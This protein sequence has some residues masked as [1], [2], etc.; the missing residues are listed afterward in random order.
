MSNDRR[1]F[2]K[3]LGVTAAAV[4]GTGCGVAAAENGATG[5]DAVA[6]GGA[7]ATVATEESAIGLA[8]RS[9]AKFG[10]ELDGSFAG[11]L[12]STEGGNAT[13]DVVTEKLGPDGIAKKHLAGVKY[14]D[15]T[16]NCGAG[17][18]KAFFQ[19]I[20]DTLGLKFTRKDGAVIESDQRGREIRRLDFK[21]ALISELDLPALDAASR[22]AAK[23]TL[24][25]SPEFTRLNQGSGAAIKFDT[26]VTL[27]WRTSDFKLKIDGL[28]EATSHA[29][30]IEAITIKQKIVEN[31]I[32]EQRDFEKVPAGL[33]FGDVHVTVPDSRAQSFYD[34][35]QDFIVQGNNGEDQERGG[36]LDYLDT[37]GRPL[38]TLTFSHLGVFRVAPV[39]SDSAFKYR[40]IKGEM[41]VERIQFGASGNATGGD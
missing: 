40:T 14:E 26:Q 34:W 16:V 23:M 39:N 1:E 31:A 20:E 10:L 15:I 38:F 9:T 22:A 5:G 30:K 7:D 25:F 8:S 3:A 4:A 6:A 36:T 17:M 37:R 2:L 13:S 32:G 29:L 24:K 19:W 28:D 18:S 35:S 27:K 33:D 21:H 11:W 12:Q 41:Y